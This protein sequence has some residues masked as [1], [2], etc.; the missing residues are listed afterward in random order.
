MHIFLIVIFMI[1]IGLLFISYKLSI[2][3]VNRLY[4]T[5]KI[6]ELQA[7]PSSFAAL[8]YVL[9][10]LSF[11]MA[12]IYS[13]TAPKSFIPIDK[14]FVIFVSI[15]FFMFFI[16]FNFHF[17]KSSKFNC[18]VKLKLLVVGNISILVVNI[19]N[20]FIVHKGLN[21]ISLAS[22]QYYYWWWLIRTVVTALVFNASFI[23]LL[24]VKIKKIAFISMGT[25]LGIILPITI[26][27]VFEYRNFF[28]NVKI[29]L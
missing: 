26:F 7:L 12:D 1:I 23:P 15:N 29:Y 4:K 3:I 16:S 28:M 27:L 8:L 14:L 9:T 24:K 22:I 20:F 18:E 13:Y 10:P 5:R 25:I 17:L 6:K 11:V 21:I 19:I 2:Y